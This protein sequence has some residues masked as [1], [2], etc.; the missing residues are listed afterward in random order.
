ME[1]STERRIAQVARQQHGL[2]TRQQ[3][4]AQGLSP[5]EITLRVKRQEWE[6]VLR[7]V[8]RLPG[9]SPSWP[10]TV[11]AS[12]LA[13]GRGAVASHRAVASLLDLPNV[14][15]RLDVTV[16]AERRLELPGLIV[17]RSRR[18]HPADLR[19][20]KGIPA[21]SPA[22]T[23]VDLASLYDR[24]QLTAVLD[25]A[26]ARRLLSRTDLVDA[27]ARATPGRQPAAG[28]QLV[29]ELLE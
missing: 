9:V 3:A 6:R 22:R 11:M 5:R 28:L 12:V 13:A 2:V 29:R 19:E 23:I 26:A 20:I 7:G 1:L 21:T 14:V 24:R 10:G 4:M 8:F 17:H 18:L 27:L 15:R 25:E 16:P